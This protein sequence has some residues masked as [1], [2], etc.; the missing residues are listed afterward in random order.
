[1]I[2]DRKSLRFKLSIPI[3]VISGFIFLFIYLLSNKVLN[4]VLF[5]Y[6]QYSIGR[7]SFEI[8]K[9]FERAIT[10]LSTA[11]L[12]S[13]ETVVEAK[14][15]DVIEEIKLY[16][17]NSNFQG[18]VKNSNKILEDTIKNI[19]R[20]VIFSKL[21][22]GKDYHFNYKGSHYHI[23]FV[24]FPAWDL[25]VITIG[26]I[27]DLSSSEKQ[28]RLLFSFLLFAFFLLIGSIFY[29]IRKN[30]LP[31]QG[32]VKDLKDSKKIRN[33]SITEL[34]IIGSAINESF[35]KLYKKTMQCQTLHN[36]AVSV[37][38]YSSEDE[39]MAI[40]IDKSINAISSKYGAIVLYDDR[41]CIRK[42]Q[43]RGEEIKI[44]TIPE[45]K[46][47][48]GLI[49]LSLTPI[50]INNVSEHP[51]FSGSFPEG[52]PVIKNIIAYPIFSSEGKPLGALYFGNKDGGFTEEDEILLK[53]ISSDVAIAFQKIE[54]MMNLE[55]FQKVIESA[56]DSIIITDYEGVIT[57]VNSAFE[58]ITGYSKEEVIGKKT[59]LL[60]SD[61]Q[62]S[63][64]YG[65]L[66]NTIKSGNTWKG[67]FIN[68]RKNGEIYY[69][70][71][72]I[73]PIEFNNKVY[74]ASIQRDITQEK[75]L[76]EQLLRAQK[77]E[78]IGTLAGGIA[79]DFNNLLTAVLG[80]S[81]IMMGSIKEG[82]PFY[83]PVNIIH[84]AAEKGAELAKKIL[85]I[86]RKEKMEM[87]PVDINEIVN[88]CIDLLQR[89]IPKNIEIITNLKKDIPKFQADPSQIQQVI[90]NLTVNAR[91]AM[92]DGG[93][94][95]IETS[96]VGSENGAANGI[97][98]DKGGFIKL[99]VSDT[100]VGMDRETQRKVFDPFFTTKET[101]K[102][103]GLGLYIVHSIVSNHKGYINLYSEPGRGT[104]FNIYLP[105]TKASDI[106]E[107]EQEIDL[108][109][110]GTIL[111]I[112]DEENMRELC[113]D[114]LE[115]LGYNVVLSSDG[116]EGLKTFRE[117]KE[118]VS[119]VIL[120]M[121]MPKVSGSEVFQALRSIKPDVK[122]ILCSGY[123]HEGFAG[124]DK[125]LKSGASGFIQ[126]PFT[127]KTLAI[128]IKK[129]LK[130]GR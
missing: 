58:K 105:I 42:I 47:I 48:L 55:K 52:H 81:E 95:I 97:P 111:V 98:F 41:G 80:Y 73:F 118:S 96:L 68:K 121:I 40:I 127:T 36:I 19:P 72:V 115:P 21:Q 93:K 87:K 4:S 31:I 88:N 82:D 33:T 22:N 24:N 59:I 5:E 9:I 60:E 49:R 46:G 75:K 117:I 35:D 13:Q 65:D 39:I 2:I 120:D 91:D 119:L 94:L 26:Q 90:M 16:W 20:E 53:A 69:T 114:I 61:Y 116:E 110:E 76:Y 29:I 113:K 43:A 112:D 86:T 34:D 108:R 104:R 17:L 92:P 11:Q 23:F 37:Y 63:Q 83:K 51:A 18:I 123:S 38:E 64:F 106:E 56:F 44:N 125:L 126:K 129:A 78:A 50:R 30:L 57:Y 12:I 1:M 77:M 122:V 15:N 7:H 99:S 103:T 10:E 45:G 101:G 6:H 71:A 62:D 3:L 54:S 25:Q 130:G 107:T 109:G 70:S 28:V 14:K 85:T 8:K 79:H 66:W 124:I 102:G 100:G 89:S 84:S 67:E 128:S 27:K 32:I 74:F